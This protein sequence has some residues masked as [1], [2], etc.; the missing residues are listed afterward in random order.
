MTTIE[1]NDKLLTDVPAPQIRRARA[2]AK[3]PHGDGW[4]V[5][6]DGNAKPAAQIQV[7][8]AHGVWLP[9]DKADSIGLFSLSAAYYEND[10]VTIRQISNGI[11]S[12]ASEKAPIEIGA[13]L[14]VTHE[15]ADLVIVHVE[16]S[17]NAYNNWIG[18]YNRDADPQ[19]APPLRYYPCPDGPAQFKIS[20][21]PVGQYM[22]GAFAHD[23][24]EPVKSVKIE[25]W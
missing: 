8:T 22:I 10:G 12:P 3:N 14:S 13:I 1:L 4:L 21:L 5:K 20:K 2:L 7:K 23:C 11:A 17:E 16:F 24:H 6:V 18:V 25:I 9:H 19:N 15:D